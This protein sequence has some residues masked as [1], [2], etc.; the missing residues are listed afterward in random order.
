MINISKN[1]NNS[2]KT[3]IECLNQ[4]SHLNQK[5]PKKIGD[6]RIFLIRHGETNW[7]KE[8]RFQG[9]IDIPLNQQ[10]KSQANAASKFLKKVSIQKAFSS[11]LSRPKE[12]AQIILKEH[13][14]IEII[15][16]ENLKEI[17]HGKWEGKLESEIED[18]WE[19]LLDLWKKSPDKVQMP[20]G[21]SIQDVW[22][23]AVSCW[24]RI[25]DSLSSKETAKRLIV[26]PHLAAIT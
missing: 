7:N 9:Q 23:R 18:K 3:Q 22:D 16:K 8:G 12:T 17:G 11:S 10:G 26:N 2:Y 20:N 4:T 1:N 24:E 5:I 14:G 15:L 19:D 6:S 21:E 25:R 13:R